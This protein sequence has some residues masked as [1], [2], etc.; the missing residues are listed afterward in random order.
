MTLSQHIDSVISKYNGEFRSENDTILCNICSKQINF[1]S[2]NYISNAVTSHLK[3]K[4]HKDNKALNP[5][6]TQQTLRDCLN[7]V[8]TNEFAKDLCNLLT[9][10]NIPF[11][12]IDNPEFQKWYKKYVK[13][14]PPSRTNVR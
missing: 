10:C 9:V 3:T 14:C 13:V 2:E 5:K 6:P 7:K 11:N 8:A 12:V 4:M 1:T